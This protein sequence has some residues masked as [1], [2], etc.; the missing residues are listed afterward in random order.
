ML[1]RAVTHTHKQTNTCTC[2]HTHLNTLTNTYIRQ[3][4]NVW[5]DRWQLYQKSFFFTSSS[6]LF[7]LFHGCIPP[8]SLSLSL[9]SCRE[10]FRKQTWGML[11]ATLRGHWCIALSF[12]WFLSLY[13]F[14]ST[15][16]NS[17]ISQCTKLQMLLFDLMLITVSFG[18]CY[19]L[20]AQ[21]NTNNTI[22]F[23]AYCTSGK[24]KKV[25]NNDCINFT[26]LH[27]TDLM[28]LTANAY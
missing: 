10:N 11:L 5:H 26:A 2:T 21:N 13:L 1:V 3:Y 24:F 25:F 17:T 16:T 28:F 9:R 6:R 15:T 18:H 14:D 20:C 22:M 4:L 7:I 19:Y 12:W 8:L 23:A 27:G